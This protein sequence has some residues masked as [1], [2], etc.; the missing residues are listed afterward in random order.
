MSPKTTQ[1]THN[2]ANE[3]ADHTGFFPSPTVRLDRLFADT[4]GPSIYAKL[5]N[6]QMSG[7]TKERTAKS[8]LDAA[9]ANGDLTPGGTVVESTSGN[10]G[11]ALARQCAVHAVNFIAVV[12]ERANV[13]A[14]T[15]MRAYGAHVE[16]VPTPS[17]GNRLRARVER[18]QELIA[19]I[20]GA[21]TTNQYGNPANPRAHA[22]STFPEIC[23]ELGG[24][25]DRLFVA[26]STT[27]TVLGCLD[28]VEATG[29]S[30]QV[31]AVDAQGSALFG[32]QSGER[33]LPGLGAGFVT[34]LSRR[35]HPHQV[36]RISEQDMIRGCRMLARREG[37]LAGASTG[38]L[39]AAVGNQLADASPSERWVFL[40]HDGG[41]P[42]LPTVYDDVWVH[43][44]YGVDP[45]RDATLS[46]SNPFTSL[47]EAA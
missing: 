33:F 41:L 47:V 2:S 24:T 21:Y 8:L 31:V 37:I 43:D 1:T 12:D 20:P 30:T 32:G 11:M 9:I 18:V 25:P 14:C 17:D 15:V 46:L 4:Q 27:G 6:L 29:A 26:T 3:T 38:A 10:L 39:V 13:A 40:V 23:A 45:A 19:K 34:D 28:A 5:D 16:L 35:A 22:G 44:T 42:Y 36:M 7:S